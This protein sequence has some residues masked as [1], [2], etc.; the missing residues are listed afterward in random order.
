MSSVFSIAFVHA[1]K[2]ASSTASSCSRSGGFAGS[3]ISSPSGSSLSDPGA[4]SIF[5]VFKIA[6]F[7][8][9]AFT[10]SWK[11]WS[12][13]P[14]EK[15][16]T[17]PSRSAGFTGP[18]DRYDCQ[19]CINWHAREFKFPTL[20]AANGEAWALYLEIQGQQRGGGFGPAGLD[21]TVLPTV[22]DLHQVPQSERL[23]LYQKILVIDRCVQ[24]HEAAKREKERR[25]C[26]PA[27]SRSSAVP[28]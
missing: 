8:G 4:F 28:A 20:G 25:R 14:S 12:Q 27:D 9:D 21:M 18:S 6:S 3:V 17:V 13:R 19:A 7:C 1:S 26:I 23:G 16:R 11:S 24:E 10:V 5:P 15:R 2:G 22:F